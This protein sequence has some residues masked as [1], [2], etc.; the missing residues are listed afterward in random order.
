MIISKGIREDN[1]ITFDT[2]VCKADGWWP[3]PVLEWVD[4]HGGLISAEETK[5]HLD[6]NGFRVEKC[7]FAHER[8][9]DYYICRLTQKD[10]RITSQREVVMETKF[11]TSGRIP[12]FEKKYDSP[13][14]FV[15]LVMC[16]CVVFCRFKASSA[17]VHYICC[18]CNSCIS[19]F[20]LLLLLCWCC[21]C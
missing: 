6:Q 18:V 17:L 11:I 8:N 19:P 12:V 15:S 20:L 14:S 3:E 21:C 2:L 7:L 9:T 10:G 1:G 13:L 4:S 16:V 5:K